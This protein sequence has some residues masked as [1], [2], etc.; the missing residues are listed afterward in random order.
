MKLSMY[1]GTTLE[2]EITPLNE[3]DSIITLAD[4]DRVIF[5]LKAFKPPGGTETLIA[6][7]LTAADYNADG[8]LTICIKP[9]ETADIPPGNYI[10]DCGIQFTDGSFYI[11]IPPDTFELRF[12]CSEKAKQEVDVSGKT[13]S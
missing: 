11:F 4:G 5:T 13:S 3:D 9:E 7:E 10:Y 6:R 1:K 8:K 2:L 12:C